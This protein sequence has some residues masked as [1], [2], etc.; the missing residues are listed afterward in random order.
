MSKVDG[1]K[2]R[3]TR[4]TAGLSVS[5][6]AAKAQCSIWN[7][8]KIERGTGQ[9]SAETY[10]LIKQALRADDTDLLADDGEAA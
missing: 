8:Y 10:W 3:A 7:I 1:G 2:L 5:A 9:P 4:F 6:L